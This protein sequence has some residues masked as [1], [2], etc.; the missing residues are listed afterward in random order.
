MDHL[1]TST[2]NADRTEDSST[3]QTNTDKIENLGIGIANIDRADIA[4]ANGA[5]NLNITIIDKADNS[6][7]C[8]ADKNR[9]KNLGIIYINKDNNLCIG[10]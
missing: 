5:K 10:K 1:S 6:S 2:I 9:A 7:I 8:I 3:E 4:N